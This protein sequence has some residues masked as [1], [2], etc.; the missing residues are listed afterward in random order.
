MAHVKDDHRIETFQD[1][2]RVLKSHPD[3]LEE[4]RSLIYTE[5]LKNLPKRFDEFLKNEFRPLKRK[6]DKIERDVE[7]LK[8]DVEVLKSDV[9]I[10]KSDV[11]VLKSDVS[12]LKADVEVLKADMKVQKADV[13]SLK[14][15]NYER[16]V[17]EKAPAYFG[18]LIRRCRVIGIE[19]LNDVLEDALDGERITEEEKASA[20]MADVVVEGN[21]KHAP[22]RKV[23]LVAEVSIKVDVK[24]V[25]R[26]SKRA[27]II[28]RAFET[29]AIGVC[30]GEN[31]TRG[32]R[33][34][35][36]KLN[37]LLV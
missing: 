26:A 16:K 29:E 1:L 37:V 19:K 15:D 24:D 4:L 30:V 3:W 22:E 8:A 23:I 25:E 11:E 2:I 36:E 14:G 5:D 21:L 32:A 31:F 28:G 12:G 27:E 9:E 35:A 20:L 17:R 33:T 18:K 7:N 13:A 6:V 34:K 10:L